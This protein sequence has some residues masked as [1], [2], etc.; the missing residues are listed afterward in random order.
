MI[1]VRSP[2]VLPAMSYGAATQLVTGLILVGLAESGAVQEDIDT[3]KIAVK[4]VVAFVVA[5]L[6][7]RNRRAASVSRGALHAIGG[8]ATLNVL[9]AVLW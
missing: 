9:I 8:L 2:K 7:V 6:V 3:A 5:A 4:L 1:A